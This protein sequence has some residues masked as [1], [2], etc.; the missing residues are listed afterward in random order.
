LRHDGGHR[1][2]TGAQRVPEWDFM[3]TRFLRAMGTYVVLALLATFT[4]DGNFRLAVWIF[5]GGLA[6]KTYIAHK[7]RDL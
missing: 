6:V 4:L 1:G 5:L 2:N 7:T 3:H